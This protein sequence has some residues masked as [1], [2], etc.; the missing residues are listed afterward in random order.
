MVTEDISWTHGRAKAV[1]ADGY[2]E[3]SFPLTAILSGL[4]L[5]LYSGEW[6]KPKRVR[7][8]CA[9]WVCF[10]PKNGCLSLAPEATDVQCFGE[11]C[12]TK[13]T[14]NGRFPGNGTINSQ[15][16][17]ILILSH[18]LP[19]VPPVLGCGY[20]LLQRLDAFSGS[21]RK[22]ATDCDKM[23][24]IK[25]QITVVS[26]IS[27]CRENAYEQENVSLTSKNRFLFDSWLKYL[28]PVV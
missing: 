16:A 19:H 13:L 15:L 18:P 22:L 3:P 1:Y 21:I 11:N 12:R 8:T 23:S 24:L 4:N 9:L 5:A 17:M 27:L 6:E 2:R 25:P 26:A 7:M 10:T 28:I 14:V 20:A